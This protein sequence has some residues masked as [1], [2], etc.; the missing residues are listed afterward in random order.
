M[1]Y[2]FTRSQ[3]DKLFFKYHYSSPN[4]KFTTIYRKL[5]TRRNQAPER[6]RLYQASIGIQS[7]K[8]T[9]LLKLCHQDLIP[10]E[11][12]KFFEDLKVDGQREDNDS[13]TED[14]GEE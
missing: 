2:K 5:V 8:K 12:W 1:Q 4:Y 9:A 14:E 3:P 13:A 10:E 11:F 7:S 6:H